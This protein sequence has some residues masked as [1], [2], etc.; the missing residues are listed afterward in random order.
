MSSTMT[1]ILSDNLRRVRERMESACAR[2]GRASGD[3]T[4]VAVTKYA[5]LDSVRALV[6]LG[7]TN[8]GEGRPQQLMARAEQLPDHVRW[9][10]IGHLQRN[11]VESVLPVV[12]QIHSVDSLR[13]VEA[14]NNT[15]R[16]LGLRP[17]L[18]LE[19]NVSGESAKDGFDPTALASDWPAICRLELIA[20][21]GL[22]TMAP[23]CTCAEDARP[24]FRRLRELRDH[25]SDVSAA[26]GG[27]LCLPEL[28]MGMSG[29]FEVA[30]E[31]GAT[32]VRIG[33]RLFEGLPK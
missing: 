12:A 11:K 21:E 24:V 30:I 32:I 22:M 28:S 31:E 20:I 4:L 19:V 14:I 3:V 33:S 8:L 29:D 7:V 16:K 9:H 6:E 10:L 26:A 18:L 23:H 5:D 1:S 2:A 17:R 13:L 15:A 25:L 27:R